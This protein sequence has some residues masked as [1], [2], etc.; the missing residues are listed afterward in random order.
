MNS[1]PFVSLQ[2]QAPAWLDRLRI[3][4]IVLLGVLARLLVFAVMPDQH[5][6]D[7]HA[8]ADSGHALVTT[9]FLSSPKYMPLYP[10]WTWIWG[11]AWGVKIGDILVS[12][13][14]I[15]LIWRLAGLLM[16]DRVAALAAA[17]VAAAYPHFLFYAVSGLTE[18]L[19]A[20]LLVASFLSYY[21]RRFFWGSTLFVLTILVH[22]TLDLLA[23]ILV[24]AFARIVHR[25][26]PRE[27]GFRVA[28]YACIY[29]VLMSPWWVDNYLHYGTFVRLDLGDGIV[30]YAGNNPLNTSGGGVMGGKKGSDVDLTPFD[31]IK[32]PVKWNAAL[33]RAAWQFIRDNPGRFV[34]LAGLKFV[35]FWRLW[36]YA[37]EYEKP[38]IVAASLLSYGVLLVCSIVYLAVAGRRNFRVLLPILLLMTYLT[39]VHMVTIGSIRYRFPLEPFIVI[40]GSAGALIVTQPLIWGGRPRSMGPS[41]GGGRPRGST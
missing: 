22:P 15:W 37:G 3:G 39:L 33:E 32:D 1:T 21:Q 29:L 41:P 2:P 8:Y 18:T 20:G 10:L 17:A 23:P 31:S 16:R 28:Q 40:L 38:W 34:E 26:S 24:A 11:G 19:F 5:F 13:A 25:A 4:H 12:T 6:S 35:R 36:P 7:A 27:T 30:L 9:G 14:M